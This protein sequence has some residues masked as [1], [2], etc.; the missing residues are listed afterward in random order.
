MDCRGCV[1][2]VA[3]AGEGNMEISITAANGRNLPNQVHQVSGGMFE[4]S[5]AP[6]E[7]GRHRA[8]VLFNGEHVPGMHAF[9]RELV[10]SLE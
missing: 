5:F 3:E 9:I 4:V 10:R 1:V 6:L 8:N 7:C 2:N